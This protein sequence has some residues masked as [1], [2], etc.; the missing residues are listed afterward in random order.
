MLNSRVEMKQS[1]IIQPMF[2]V[3]GLLSFRVEIDILNGTNYD[4]FV[5]V[6]L[7]FVYSFCPD[8]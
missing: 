4:N 2:R 6:V 1:G 8:I 5:L 7:K 3:N